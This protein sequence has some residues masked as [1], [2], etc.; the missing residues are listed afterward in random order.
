MPES[1]R[2][3]LVETEGDWLV[4][5]RGSCGGGGVRAVG[6]EI[7]SSGADCYFQQRIAGESFSA[8]LVSRRQGEGGV[9]RT[10]LLGC[11]RQWLAADFDDGRSKGRQGWRAFAYRGSVGP[12][13]V[14]EL[15]K[16]QIGQIANVLGREFSLAGVWGMDF[17]LDADGQV[18]PV[19][20][21]PRITASAELFES[22][23]AN[24]SCGYCSV[25]DLHLS[26]CDSGRVWGV[27]DF[28]TL[29]GER[30]VGQGKESC[31]AKRILFFDGPGI[32]EMDPSKFQLLSRLYER[33]FF[34]GRSAGVSIADVPA[35]GDR[36]APGR[37]LMTM[38]SRAHTE[39]AALVL[40]DQL[41]VDVRGCLQD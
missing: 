39:A 18:W 16:H 10:V 38:R 24:S 25:V 33:D 26:A 22:A 28:E 4:K 36:I 34:Q 2:D 21:N 3:L 17:I 11:T 27:K 7:E 1:R 23:I 14:A 20:L 40:L 37:P 15:V 31:E 41:L 35:V 8:V 32:F 9:E 19:D 30:I 6:D 13:A 29:A 5:Q 12:I